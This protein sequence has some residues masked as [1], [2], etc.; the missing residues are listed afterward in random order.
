MTAA[1]GGIQPGGPPPG[2]TQP[3]GARPGGPAASGA[4]RDQPVVRAAGGVVWRSGPAGAEI[5]LVHRPRYDDWTLPK[6]KAE[7]GEE[8]TETARREVAE[9]TGLDTVLGDELPSTGYVDGRGRPKIVRYWV[10]TAVGDPADRDAAP[11]VPNDEVDEL[12]WLPV[13][14]ARRRLSY[15][16]DL[17][18]VDAFAGRPGAA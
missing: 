16:R 17:P 4:T 3:G 1:P 11:W 8:D 7:P 10:M 14:E 2:G 6:G 13:D 9:E 5:L 18:V 15:E 12:A